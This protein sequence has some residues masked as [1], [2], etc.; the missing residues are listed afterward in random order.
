[1]SDV[2]PMVKELHDAFMAKNP[3]AML[4]QVGCL[5]RLPDSAILPNSRIVLFVNVTDDKCLAEVRDY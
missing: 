2:S 4:G 5:P 3:N 1:M